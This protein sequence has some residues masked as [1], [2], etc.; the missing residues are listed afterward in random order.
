MEMND[1]VQRIRRTND[2]ERRI[3]GAMRMHL[4]PRMDKWVNDALPDKYNNNFFAPLTD[5]TAPEID[6]SVALQRKENHSGL[7]IRMQQRMDE[8]LTRRYGFEEAITDIMALT[9]ASSAALWR[10]N[11]AVTIRDNQQEDMTAA[12][13]DVSTTPPEYRTAALRSM[14]QAVQVSKKHPEYHWLFACLDGK[15]VGR[16]YILCRSGVI[17][18]DDLEVHKEYRGQYIA[19]TLM[20]HIAH[21]FEGTFYLHA[22][23]AATVHDMYARMGFV[24]VDT[25]YDYYLEW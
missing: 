24:T 12:M 18:M 15:P 22:D 23:C 6:A 7:M 8:A 1:L 2:Y 13:L 20:K 10:E 25:V 19:T 11:P 17:E 5:I 21:N 3:H 14:K 9:D 4:T 16:C